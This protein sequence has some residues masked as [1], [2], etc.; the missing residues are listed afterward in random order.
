MKLTITKPID[1][2][3]KFLKVDAEVRY[4]EDASVNGANDTEDGT[5]IPCKEGD[6]WKP[7]IDIDEGRIINWTKGAT[8]HIQYKVCDA[9]IYE[10]I[11]SI[12]QI[13]ATKE[14]YVP[15]IMCPADEGY[16]D[17]I[18]M[19]IDENGVIQKWRKELIK[20]FSNHEE[21]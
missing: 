5:H 17:Y 11:D 2:E 7:V 10:V 21:D 16:G 18:I 6:S 20:E 13:I 1:F 14:G 8:A 9:G 12:G 3:A 4:W 19:D 15:E